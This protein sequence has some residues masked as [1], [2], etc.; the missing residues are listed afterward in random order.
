MSQYNN[1][2]IVYIVCLRDREHYFSI[3]LTFFNKK[4]KFKPTKINKLYK[5]YK[6]M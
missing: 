5:K 2:I 1:T 4:H 6:S 3:R